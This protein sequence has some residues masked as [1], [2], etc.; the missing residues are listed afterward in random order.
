MGMEISAYGFLDNLNSGNS[1]DDYP[2]L[3]GLP[4][5]F[6]ELPQQVEGS[7]FRVIT[8]KFLN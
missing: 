5:L 6:G 3:G 1:S 2:N 8:T 7:T 4:N